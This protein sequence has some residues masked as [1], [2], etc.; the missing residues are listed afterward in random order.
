MITGH[1]SHSRTIA[2]AQKCA[3]QQESERD[4][5]ANPN[6]PFDSTV[7][8]NSEPQIVGEGFGFDAATETQLRHRLLC[9][10]IAHAAPCPRFNEVTDAE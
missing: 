2:I 6:R 3:A 8:L 4:D 7:Y 9:R 1:E 10:K 5:E